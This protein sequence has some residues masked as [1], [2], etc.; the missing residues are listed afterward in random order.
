M[1]TLFLL[2]FTASL[3]AEE[4]VERAKAALQLAEE[5]LARSFD[6]CL[7]LII[8]LQNKTELP[9]ATTKL[10]QLI[11]ISRANSLNLLVLVYL[12]KKK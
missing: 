7:L 12:S 8:Y 5:H 4:A 9:G 11:V 10:K 2:I 1:L 3:Q 6:N